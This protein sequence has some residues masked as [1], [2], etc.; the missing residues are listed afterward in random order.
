MNQ[1]INIGDGCVLFELCD[2][3]D[4]FLYLNK[5]FSTKYRRYLKRYSHIFFVKQFRIYMD[6]YESLHHDNLPIRL[7]NTYNLMCYVNT[8]NYIMKQKRIL[9][10]LF[11]L[12]IFNVTHTFFYEYG[13]SGKYK[14]LKMCLDMNQFTKEIKYITGRLRK[15]KQD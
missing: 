11:N 9:K 10:M 6:L 7:S 13:F 12:N 5:E 15:I 4:E 14:S 1:L 3:T 8:L 2:Y